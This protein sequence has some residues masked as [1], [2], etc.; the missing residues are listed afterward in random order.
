[1]KIIKKPPLQTYQSKELWQ[2]TRRVFS[3]LKE[4]QDKDT[5]I[6]RQLID[7]VTLQLTELKQIKVIDL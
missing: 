1:M 2:L 3:W 7:S 5:F 4:F 6:V